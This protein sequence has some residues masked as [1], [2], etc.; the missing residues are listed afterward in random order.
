MDAD[1]VRSALQDAETRRRAGRDLRAWL[2]W[3]EAEPGRELSAS[4]KARLAAIERLR[5]VPYR[6]VGSR[7]S[8]SARAAASGKARAFGIARPTP[9]R[10]PWLDG[11]SPLPL[12][13]P[14]KG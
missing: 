8:P 14:G 7:P 4:I 12:R 10:A 2:A 3:L 5:G 9:E 13:P 6:G 11:G 1:R